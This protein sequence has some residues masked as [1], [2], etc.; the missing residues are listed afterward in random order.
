MHVQH[1]EYAITKAAVQI[2]VVKYRIEA[3]TMQFPSGRNS[4]GACMPDS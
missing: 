1:K 3:A 4:F 2:I